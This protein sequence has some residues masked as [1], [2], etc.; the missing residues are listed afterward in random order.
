MAS[1]EKSGSI[2]LCL[3]FSLSVTSFINSISIH[4][5]SSI[6]ACPLSSCRCSTSALWSV[7]NEKIINRLKIW[8]FRVVGKGQIRKNLTRVIFYASRIST[9]NEIILLLFEVMIII[10]RCRQCDDGQWVQHSRI[11]HCQGVTRPTMTQL[12][13]DINQ[14]EGNRMRREKADGTAMDMNCVFWCCWFFTQHVPFVSVID[15]FLCNH[16]N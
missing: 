11:I 12:D 1:R 7:P 8:Y 15:L 6:L 2:E 10:D 4:I 16:S 13:I 3:V 14:G 9:A 5:N